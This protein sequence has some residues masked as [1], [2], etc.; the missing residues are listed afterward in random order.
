MD[1]TSDKPDLRRDFLELFYPIQYKIGL[2][3]EDALRLGQLTR[4]QV[5]ILWLIRC[6]GE[7]GRSMNRKDIQTMLTSWFEVSNS[8]ITKALRSMARPPLG[9]VRVLEDP[10][11]GRQKK[12]VLTTKGERFIEEMIERGRAFIE[13]VVARISADEAEIG[14]Q[15]L[16]KWISTVETLSIATLL[17]SAAAVGS[18]PS[19]PSSVAPPAPALAEW[20]KA[21]PP[22]KNGI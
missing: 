22:S 21:V 7:G 18:K 16:K 5:V 4:K 2:A 17:R 15:F 11:S 9:L 1:A 10:Q 3:L 20:T 19:L 6:E 14:L 12:I 8:T 13:P